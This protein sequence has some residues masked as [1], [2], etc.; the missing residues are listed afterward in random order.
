[1]KT[2]TIPKT[3]IADIRRLASRFDARAI[4]QCIQLAL[5]KQANPCYS[6]EESTE[7]LNVLAKSSFVIGQMQEGLSLAQAIRELGR[8]MRAIQDNA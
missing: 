1:M 6:A 5:A 2:Q 8:R 3:H 7:V 4:E